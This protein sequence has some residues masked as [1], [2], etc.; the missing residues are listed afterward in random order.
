MSE[1]GSKHRKVEGIRFSQLVDSKLT[2]PYLRLQ[3]EVRKH[4]L[5]DFTGPVCIEGRPRRD[6]SDRVAEEA[7][8]VA[9]GGKAELLLC[10]NPRLSSPDHAPDAENF[11]R[12][13]A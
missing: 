9:D 13:D 3:Q 1:M 10:A 11:A 6:C 12:I 8:M 4:P 5:Q 7:G 2:R